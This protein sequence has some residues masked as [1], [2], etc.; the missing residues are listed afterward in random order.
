[1]V[2][3]KKLKSPYKPKIIDDDITCNFEEEYTSMPIEESP[4]AEWISDYQEW[5]NEFDKDIDELDND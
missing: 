1:M 2:N 3:N 5:F 4:V